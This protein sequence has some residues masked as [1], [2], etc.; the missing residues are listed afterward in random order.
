MIT[1]NEVERMRQEAVEFNDYSIRLWIVLSLILSLASIFILSKKPFLD[2]NALYATALIVPISCSL[3]FRNRIARFG[4][5]A[6]V[7]TL[8]GMLSVGV[9]FGI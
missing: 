6:Y 2:H 8:V 3:Y 9:Y 1:Y 4:P 5:L 7:A